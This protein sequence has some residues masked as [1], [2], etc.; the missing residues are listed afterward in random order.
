MRRGLTPLA[1]TLIL[2]V[3][4]IALGATVMTWGE[5]FIEERAQFAAD[6]ATCEATSLQAITIQG[7]SAVCYDE[8]AI[9]TFIENNANIALPE[10]FVQIIA[11]DITSI[12]Q[13]LD[14]AARSTGKATI[15]YDSATHGIPRQLRISPSIN[16]ACTSKTII[17]EPIP[18]CQ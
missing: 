2:V 18:Y 6:P 10:L 4:S 3:V 9:H 1:S 17:L 12:T 5:E 13:S 11:K 14:L 16:G 7:V 8:Q 15:P